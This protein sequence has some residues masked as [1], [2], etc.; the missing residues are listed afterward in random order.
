MLLID[1]HGC[2]CHANLVAEGMLGQSSQQL[3]GQPVVDLLAS[4]EDL[5]TLWSAASDGSVVVLRLQA[6]WYVS[7][8][9][10]GRS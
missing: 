3:I 7:G 4:P 9:T 6:R 2:V 8:A 10:E 1:N 5:D